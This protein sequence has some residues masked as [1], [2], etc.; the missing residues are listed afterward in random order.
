VPHTT[1]GLVDILHNLRRR[2][3]P[4][5]LE[6]LLPDVA[7]IA[8]DDGLRDTAKELMD[9]NGL[10]VL[11]DRVKG[12]LNHMTAKGIHGEVQGIASNGLS[13]LD[14]LFRSTMF[15]ATL[16]QEIAEAVDLDSVSIC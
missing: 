3:G 8:M 5:K 11:G 4:A 6:K 16:D 12:L 1:E 7:S 13:N 9:H 10:V 15:E 14:D 2:L